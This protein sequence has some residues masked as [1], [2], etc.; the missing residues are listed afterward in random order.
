MQKHMAIVS[1]T[2]TRNHQS[3]G[4]FREED[5]EKQWFIAHHTL[6]PSQLFHSRKSDLEHMVSSHA[7]A[8]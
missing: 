4:I 5:T 3:K 2:H 8:R 1:K 7:K 6:E